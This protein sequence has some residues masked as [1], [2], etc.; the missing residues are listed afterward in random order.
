MSPEF[1]EI[2]DL[3]RKG[4]P[5]WEIWKF[6]LNSPRHRKAW[7]SLQKYGPEE[8]LRWEKILE[9]LPELSSK[10][11][12]ARYKAIWLIGNFWPEMQDLL[13]FL[14]PYYH[15]ASSDVRFAVLRVVGKVVQKNPEMV[16]EIGPFLQDTDENIR[17]RAC[18]SLSRLKRDG[19]FFLPQLR[20]M[21]PTASDSLK[22]YI[23]QVFENI[24]D[25]SKETL[26][27]LYSFWKHPLLGTYIDQ[28]LN[29]L[30]EKN[31]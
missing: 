2:Q 3:R 28:T 31:K 16:E 23:L 12:N 21:F 7:S 13:P 10:K 19:Q 14:K 1:Q 27:L 4:S 22:K 30:F 9:V 29:S 24:G 15:D 6:I 20:Q 5:P 8:M 17:K 18:W 11:S 25:T 26:D